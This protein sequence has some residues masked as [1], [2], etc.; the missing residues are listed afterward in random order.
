ME[1]PKGMT[2]ICPNCYAVIEAL[3][4]P[5]CEIEWTQDEWNEDMEEL[6]KRLKKR[7]MPNERH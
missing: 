7:M 5:H 4:C 6:S 3:Y 2:G 1:N